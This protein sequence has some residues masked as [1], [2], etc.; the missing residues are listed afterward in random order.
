MLNH[1]Q[2]TYYESKTSGVDIMIII[3]VKIHDRTG[4]ESDFVEL[5]L[6]DV[7]YIDLWQPTKSKE[8]C[9]AYHTEGGSYLSLR[10]LKDVSKAYANYGFKP[11]DSS[12]IINENR[13][14]KTETTDSGSNIY[15]D[16]GTFVRVRSKL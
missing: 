9:P 4:M 5:S 8:K 16:D 3:G 2:L 1:V 13:I 7:N 15:F 12:T 10:T 11:Y 6:G 14:A